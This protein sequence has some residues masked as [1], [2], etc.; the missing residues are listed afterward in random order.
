MQFQFFYINDVTTYLFNG[1]S[2][3]ILFMTLFYIFASIIGIFKLWL[4]HLHKEPI[5]IFKTFYLIIFIYNEKFTPLLITIWQG[6]LHLAALL[7]QADAK[8][9]IPDSVFF[10]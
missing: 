7:L 3:F 9:D 8:P 2:I 10:L 4:L 6:S 1:I 5:L